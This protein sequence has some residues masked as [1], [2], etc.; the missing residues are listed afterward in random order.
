M[1]FAARV[2]CSEARTGIYTEHGRYFAQPS[3]LPTITGEDLDAQL[4]GTPSFLNFFSERIVGYIQ[5]FESFPGY[6][7]KLENPAKRQV[8]KKQQLITAAFWN[9]M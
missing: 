3:C 6:M 9:R 1:L 5:I 8:I 7:N 2:G 4:L